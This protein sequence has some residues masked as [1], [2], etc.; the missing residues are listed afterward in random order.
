M[1]RGKSLSE[2][3]KGKIKAFRELGLTQRLI[4]KKINRSQNL[5]GLY[6][7]NIHKYGKNQKGGTY[8]A[9]SRADR[10]SIIKQL[11]IRII[12]RQKLE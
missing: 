1:G 5:I 8:R 2:E 3:E 9:T 4:A 12:P 10:R 11:L 7:R 6:L